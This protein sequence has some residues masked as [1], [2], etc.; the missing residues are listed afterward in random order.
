MAEDAPTEPQPTKKKYPLFVK[1]LVAIFL[2]VGGFAG[3][4]LNQPDD[5]RVERSITISASP[6]A[7]FEHINDFHNWEAWSPWAKLDPKATNSY[8]G[9]DAGLDAKFQWAGNDKVGVGSMTITESYPQER[10][11]MR[12]DFEKPMQDTSTAEFTF[13]PQGEQ[14]VVT[15]AMYGR[16]ANFFAKA[17]C[18]VMNM[19][20]MVGGKFDEGLASLKKTVEAGK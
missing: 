20:R 13:R 8:E 17:M 14:T 5:F 18:K 11:R 4:I 19:D 12:L 2:A 9:P 7:I 15:W 6:E 16:Y 3:Y 10:I 1:I